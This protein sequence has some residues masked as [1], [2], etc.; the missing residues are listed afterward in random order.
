MYLFLFEILTTASK[1]F[2]I[3]LKDNFKQEKRTIFIKN[4]KNIFRW[5]IDTNVGYFYDS[6]FEEN[7]LIVGQTR[8]RKTT[9]VQKLAKKKMFGVIKEAYWLSKIS[10]PK[11]RDDNIIDCFN[12]EVNFKYTNNLEEFDT[13][14]DFFQ[15]RIDKSSCIDNLMIKIYQ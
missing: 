10:L 3:S 11:G 5:T 6:K 1:F 15:K 7:I 4:T 9:F 13:L 2:N 8:C 12:V 14:L